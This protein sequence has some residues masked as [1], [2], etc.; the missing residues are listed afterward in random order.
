MLALIRRR[1]L[2]RHAGNTFPS[3]NRG[4][5]VLRIYGFAESVECEIGNSP[6]RKKLPKM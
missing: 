3:Y 6:E 2:V 1:R 4:H 5:Q